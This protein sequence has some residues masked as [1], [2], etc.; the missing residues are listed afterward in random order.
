MALSTHKAVSKRQLEQTVDKLSGDLEEASERI[1][2]LESYILAGQALVEEE[3]E[4]D[5]DDG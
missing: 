1:D 3:D 4:E 5:E 2:E